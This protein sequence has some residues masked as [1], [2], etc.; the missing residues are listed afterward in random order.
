MSSFTAGISFRDPATNSNII[1]DIEKRVG[2]G[3]GS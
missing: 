2:G 1:T 3:A